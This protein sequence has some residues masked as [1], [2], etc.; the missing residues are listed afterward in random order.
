MPLPE[1]PAGIIRR[2]QDLGKKDLIFVQQ[3]TTSYGMI[4]IQA[5]SVSSGQQGS[6]GGGTGG[7]YVKITEV[8]GFLAELIQV[9]GTDPGIAMASQVSIALIICDQQ[10]DVGFWCFFPGPLPLSTG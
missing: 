2:S 7:G 3:G 4:D 1:H 6:P 9:R 5:I 10:D 8:N